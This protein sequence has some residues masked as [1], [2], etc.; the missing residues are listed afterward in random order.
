VVGVVQATRAET[1]TNA[2]TV[3]AIRLIFIDLPNL[4]RA[5]LA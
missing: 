3:A 2:A 1:A 5:V 4:L